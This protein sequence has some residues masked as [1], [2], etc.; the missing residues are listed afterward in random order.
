MAKTRQQKEAG[1]Q[2]LVEQ[3]KSAKA[4]VFA[5][6]QGLKVKESEELRALCRKENI[7][8]TA[9]K[10]TLVALALKEAGFD[11]DAKTFTGGV[12]IACGTADDVAPAQIVANFAKKHEALEILGG[13]KLLIRVVRVI[14]G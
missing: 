11:A 8:Y 1:L 14:R 13:L 2:A 9:G 7:T 4:V 10:K 5:N 6:F 3:L 12:S